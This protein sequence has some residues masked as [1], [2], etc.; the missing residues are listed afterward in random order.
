MVES[1]IYPD[2]NW[3]YIE[4][5]T[6]GWSE[7]KLEV[8][9]SYFDELNSTA[10]L[11][12]KN[13]QIVIEWGDTKQNYN[14]R[15]IRK[16]FLSALFGIYSANRDI[17]ILETLEDLSI[18]DNKKLSPQEKQAQIT[19]LLRAKSGVYHEAINE[20]PDMKKNRPKR[21]SHLA[22]RKWFYNNWDFNTLGTIFQEQ[23]SKDLFDAFIQDIAKPINM[24]NFTIKDTRY[25][26]GTLSKHPAYMF[27]MNAR[28]RARFGLLYLRD[29]KWQNKQIIPKGW[30]RESTKPHTILK[31]QSYGYMWWSSINNQHLGFDLSNGSF[32]AWGILCHFITVIPKHDMVIVHISDKLSGGKNITKQKF[33]K[34]LHKVIDASR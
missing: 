34:L 33:G 16:S 20:S 18:D 29:G 8:A 3:T 9:K 17:D 10:L 6:L 32:S 2:K 4:P 19:D 13:G 23:T 12:I 22:G 7:Q 28:D 14:C 5:T 26:N 30:I 1:K 24:E 27:N 31:N 21:G 15:S 11:V 25:I